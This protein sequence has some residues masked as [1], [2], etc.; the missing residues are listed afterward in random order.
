M[1]A[2]R[3]DLEHRIPLKTL[4]FHEDVMGTV[5]TIDV[6]DEAG[7]TPLRLWPHLE[8]ARTEL[9]LADQI[10][11]IWR[12]DSPM[13]RL[14]RGE[15]SLADAPSEMVD[16]FEQCLV[17]RTLS[18]GWFD[19]WAMPGGVDPT[20][21][22]KGWAAQRALE[23]LAAAGVTGA[24]VNA[25]GDVTTWGAPAPNAVW[26]TGIVNPLATGTLACVV[27]LTG[28]IA[29]SGTYERGEHLIDPH[30]GAP[31]CRVASASVCGPDL[32]LADALA[33]A[34]AVGGEEVLPRVEALT[35][36][37]GL[38]IDGAGE[39]RATSSFPLATKSSA[40]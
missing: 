4:H 33:T 17:A 21:Y 34:L 40:S 22:V 13:S 14:R 26:R 9:H 2:C 5:V 25:A 16:V 31:N 37:E 28:A 7:I 18:G 24:V 32:G 35:G 8:M 36:Y 30:S 39:M 3:L 27:E 15:L 12:E 6:Y 1:A 19:P 23:H 10:F 38:I 11:S 29:T 20:G